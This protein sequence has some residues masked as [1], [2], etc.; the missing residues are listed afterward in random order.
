MLGK[1][2]EVLKLCLIG[3]LFV[4]NVLSYFGSYRNLFGSSREPYQHNESQASTMSETFC[5]ITVLFNPASY[6]S[7]YVSY[8]TFEKHMRSF[9]VR[10][11]TVELVF[12]N[13]SFRVTNASDQNHVQLRTQ[14]VMWFK[15]NLINIGIKRSPISCVY[16]AWVDIE[17]EFLNRDWLQKTIEALEQFKVVQLFEVVNILGPNREPLETH[18]GF[19]RCRSNKSIAGFGSSLKKLQTPSGMKVYCTTGFAWATKKRLL[20]QTGGLYDKGKYRCGSGCWM[21]L[22]LVSNCRYHRRRGP[23]KRLVICRKNPAQTLRLQKHIFYEKHFQ[24]EKLRRQAHTWKSWVR[25]RHNQPLVARLTL[26]PKLLQPEL[27]P[28][29]VVQSNKPSALR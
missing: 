4:V 12:N 20:E 22:Y 10:L 9:G 19:G 7:R 18:L 17:V 3:F 8:N 16:L 29:L 23:D 21:G 26:R 15:E 6:E 11:I 2:I 27:S 5:V 13:Q 14:D 1:Q 28:P 25:A 24:L